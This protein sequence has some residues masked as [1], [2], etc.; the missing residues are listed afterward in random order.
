LSDNAR[1]AVIGRCKCCCLS[2][3]ARDAVIG[4]CR[5]CCLSDN[6]RDAVIGRCRCC[7]LSDNA[8]DAVRSEGSSLALDES[9][10]MT[11][12]DVDADIPVNCAS[13]PVSPSTAVS[14]CCINVL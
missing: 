6:A 7:C 9:E 8:R 4:R 2:D 12:S 3:N 11:S 1:D 5:C 13:S 10:M 14:M